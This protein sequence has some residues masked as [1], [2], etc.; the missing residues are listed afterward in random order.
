MCKGSYYN[1]TKSFI[2][3][4]EKSAACKQASH[5]SKQYLTD[6]KTKYVKPKPK[7]AALVFENN[8]V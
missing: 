2:D 3:N 6:Y 8:N 1:F 5:L 7:V 4:F